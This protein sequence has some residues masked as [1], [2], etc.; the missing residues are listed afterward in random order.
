M[1]YNKLFI[2]DLIIWSYEEQLTIIFIGILDFNLF[3][4][5]EY[6]TNHKIINEAIDNSELR[7][8]EFYFIELKKFQKNLDQ[9]YKL[10]DK[11][12]YFLKNISNYTVIHEKLINEKYIK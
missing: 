9:I 1:D 5:N 12:I 10:S 2:S 4:G 3:D 7:L 11:W 8:M 6:V